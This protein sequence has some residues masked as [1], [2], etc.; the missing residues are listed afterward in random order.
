VKKLMNKPEHF[1]DEML[2]GLVLAN[3]SL[4]RDGSAGRVIRRAEPAG[5]GKV[6]VVSGGGSGHLPLFTGY[7]G[8]GLLDSCSIGNVFEGPNVD[9]CMEAM[10]LVDANTGEDRDPLLIDR[11]TGRAFQPEDTILVPGPAADNTVHERIAQMKAWFLGF[12][13]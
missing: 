12:D 5:E 2:E 9:S 10:R 7:V 6:G 1:V 13:A 3:P 11:V 8:K 4:Q